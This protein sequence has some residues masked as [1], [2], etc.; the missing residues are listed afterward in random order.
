MASASRK[1]ST[2]LAES[3]GKAGV[4]SDPALPAT[5]ATSAQADPE[6]MVRLGW[7]FVIVGFLGFLLW[8][9][10]APLDQGVPAPGVVVVDGQRKTVQHYSGGIVGEIFVQDGQK[11]QAGDPLIALNDV[12][13][14]AARQLARTQWVSASAREARLVAELR[15]DDEVEFPPELQAL[16]GSDAVSRTLA[17]QQELLKSRRQVFNAEIS[18]L[19][20]AIRGVQKQIAAMDQTMLSRERELQ[21][22]Q[23]QLASLSGLV[24]EGFVSRNRVL[25]FERQKAQLETTIAASAGERGRLES[26][27]AEYKLSLAQRRS[28]TSQVIQTELTD[29]Q[30]EAEAAYSRLVA[31]EFDLDHAV[32]KAPVDGVVVGMTV[33]TE[34]GVI[35]A[36]EKLLDLVP[37]NRPLEVQAEFPVHLI[38]SIKVGLPVELMFSALNLNV[39]PVVEGEVVH[40][41]A[42]RLTAE[43]T[44]E[45]F[46]KVTVRA[47]EKG[48]EQ[49]KGQQV[50]PGMPVDVFIKTGERSLMN[51]LIKPLRD[52]GAYALTE[53]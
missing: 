17:L 1:G 49:L 20:E 15:G 18:A 23:S 46:Y 25:D 2:A 45:P 51:Y 9:A 24:S 47:T 34:G 10:F 5:I 29:M 11:V 53:K 42:D 8:A 7:I 19:E 28:E 16:S 14:R 37:E 3:T 41:S 21:A 48:L 31:A 44:G 13:I 36:G 26:Q 33:F 27:L 22:V 35:G 38:D 32:I 12:P 6:P 4:S 39:T 50:R 43:R 40:V 52:R 30:R